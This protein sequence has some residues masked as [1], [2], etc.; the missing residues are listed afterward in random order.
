M[1]ASLNSLEKTLIDL[2]NDPNADQ[3]MFNN[4]F[5]KFYDLLR[6]EEISSFRLGSFVISAERKFNVKYEDYLSFVMVDSTNGTHYE[7][8][9]PNEEKNF[10]LKIPQIEEKKKGFDVRIKKSLYDIMPKIYYKKETAYVDGIINEDINIIFFDEAVEYGIEKF[11][12][13]DTYEPDSIDGGEVF[14]HIELSDP[15]EMVKVEDILNTSILNE[16][17]PSITESAFG[18][19][20]D[21]FETS[22]YLGNVYSSY[23]KYDLTVLQENV[24]KSTVLY[25]GL[26]SYFA[27]LRSLI[28]LK[29]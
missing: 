8:H 11:L 7:Y 14:Y 1:N 4:V 22:I 29:R 16:Y 24:R 6:E 27:N 9:L 19:K 23:K 28:D 18:D 25:K 20:D 13:T 15:N 10:A 26:V 5:S 2:L 17:Y 12:K 3:V 21:S